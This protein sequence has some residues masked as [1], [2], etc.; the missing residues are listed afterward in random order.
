[1]KFVLKGLA[2]DKFVWHQAITWTKL[3]KIIYQSTDTIFL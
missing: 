1:M 3:I 2:V